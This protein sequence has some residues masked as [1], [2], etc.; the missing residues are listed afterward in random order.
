MASNE[1]NSEMLA[2]LTNLTERFE[3]R[4]DGLAREVAGIKEKLVRPSANEAEAES[5]NEPEA[6]VG[7]NAKPGTA[8]DSTKIARRDGCT[9]APTAQI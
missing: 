5:S 8:Q 9:T 7:R 4:F 2:M 1:A 6:E 3:A